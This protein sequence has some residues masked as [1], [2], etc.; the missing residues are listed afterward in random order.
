MS[1]SSGKAQNR[2]PF[3]R[4]IHPRSHGSRS[5]CYSQPDKLATLLNL[6]RLGQC[7]I[8]NLC[9]VSQSHLVTKKEDAKQVYTK[10]PT[11]SAQALDP[12]HLI[13]QVQNIPLLSNITHQYISHAITRPCIRSSYTRHYQYEYVIY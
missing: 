8:S 10:H 5:T 4:V 9:G 6:I 11:T 7:M 3:L 13:T 12:I 1:R 2:A